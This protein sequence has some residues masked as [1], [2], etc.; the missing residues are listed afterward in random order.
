M[1]CIP[2]NWIIPP[3]T[4]YYIILEQDNTDCAGY[5]WNRDRHTWNWTDLC[6]WAFRDK[7]CHFQNN[8]LHF[9]EY[10]KQSTNE[11]WGEDRGG[12]G[13]GGSLWYFIAPLPLDLHLHRS[14][15]PIFL[16]HHPSFQGTHERLACHIFVN[17]GSRKCG[18][19]DNFYHRIDSQG[20]H[21]WN[22][23][24]NTIS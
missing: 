2:I 13:G 21:S 3:I 24:I 7:M 20:I 23:D 5:Y 9:A 4:A 1:K 8:Y 14:W 22:Y 6:K 19:N 18:S 15:L 11:W 12:G 10:Q 16:W 17:I